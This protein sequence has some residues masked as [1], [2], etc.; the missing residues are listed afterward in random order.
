MKNLIMTG[1][2]AC[3]LCAGGYAEEYMKGKAS[4]PA[5]QTVVF[6]E[7]GGAGAKTIDSGPS[8]RTSYPNDGGVNDSGALPPYESYD[9]NTGLKNVVPS[10][11]S[12][13]FDE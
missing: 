3:A 8:P 13:E 6:E 4:Y 7:A 2:F 9:P 10:D 1:V 12:G 11:S 5:S